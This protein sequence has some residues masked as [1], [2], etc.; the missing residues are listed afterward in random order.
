MANV[1][2]MDQPADFKNSGTEPQHVAVWEDGKR[3]DDRAGAFEWWYFDAVLDDGSKVVIPFNT[4]GNQNTQLDGAQPQVMITITDPDGKKYTDL[5]KYT[6]DEFQY[7][8]Q[9]CDVRIGPHHVAGDLKTYQIHV[10]PV[11][12]IG[13][14][15]TLTSTSTP[16][17]AGN[18]YF[19]FGND[20]YFTWLCVVPRGEITGTLT[21]NGQTVAVTG[22]GYH[23]HQWGNIHH[24]M[25]WNNWLWARQNF[26]DYAIVVFD[27][28]A[29]DTYGYKHMPLTFIQDADGEIIYQNYDIKNTKYQVLS[30]YVQESTGKSYPKKSRYTFDDHGKKIEYEL[31][32]KEEL[33]IEDLYSSAPAPAKKQF[34][35]MNIKPTY[36]REFA[37]GTLTF[38]QGG[39]L[40]K[41]SGDMI[42]EFVYVGKEYRPMMEH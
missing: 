6:A 2:I 19:D 4:K 28:V 13:A 20:N 38:E 1:R 16:W 36:A 32:V 30:E 27:F 3:D 17:R 25:A 11:N 14:D 12:G 23:D 5:T 42:Y 34:D 15:L 9:R 39:Q 29:R 18:G 40:V 7:S 31:S 10:E 33:S 35:Q 21:Y 26:D 8:K 22:R 37:T 41:R 24:V